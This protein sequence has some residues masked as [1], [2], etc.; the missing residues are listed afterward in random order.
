MAFSAFED[1][2][3]VRGIAQEAART[4]HG[5]F[6]SPG[7][8]NTRPGRGRAA[9]GIYPLA[10]SGAAWYNISSFSVQAEREIEDPNRE[11]KNKL[12]LAV[13]AGLSWASSIRYCEAFSIHEIEA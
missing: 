13:S 1:V 4:A 7:R 8:R 9:G 12:R 2:G 10:R 11:P 3:A 5:A 6:R